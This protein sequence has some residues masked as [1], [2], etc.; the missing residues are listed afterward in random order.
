MISSE[1]KGGFLGNIKYDRLDVS[2]PSSTVEIYTF[3]LDGKTAGV[4]TITYTNNCKNNILS[5]ERS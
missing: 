3:T 4:I 5:V 1:K 2:Y